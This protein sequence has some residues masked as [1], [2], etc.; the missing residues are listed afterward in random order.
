MPYALGALLSLAHMPATGKTTRTLAVRW[1]TGAAS[2]EGVSPLILLG[3]AGDWVP[4]LPS[5]VQTTAGLSMC[6]SFP[7]GRQRVRVQ[8]HVPRKAGP[9]HR[10][11]APFGPCLSFEL[12]SLS[13]LQSQAESAG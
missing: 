8:G 4:Q 11:G 6:P 9:R 2:I 12:L 1:Q 3:Y 5:V 13:I 7:R 10:G